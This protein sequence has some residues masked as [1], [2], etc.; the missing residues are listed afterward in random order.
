ME[1]ALLPIG[2]LQAAVELLEPELRLGAQVQ[3]PPIEMFQLHRKVQRH[4]AVTIQMGE[5][6]EDLRSSVHL[7]WAAQHQE[8]HCD[9]KAGGCLPVR[10]RG[11]QK[12]GDLLLQLLETG[13]DGRSVGPECDEVRRSFLW[14]AATTLLLSLLQR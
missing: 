2:L 4:R 1:Q 10:G 3:H 5:L 7:S 9:M 13:E 6:S 11:R 8:A 14:G 12:G